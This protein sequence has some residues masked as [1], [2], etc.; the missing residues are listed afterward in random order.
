MVVSDL[1]K[2][3]PFWQLYQPYDA[4]FSGCG[5]GSWRR[6]RWKNNQRATVYGLDEAIPPGSYTSPS[7]HPS[8]NAIVRANK[9]GGGAASAQSP[10]RPAEAGATAFAAKPRRLPSSIGSNPRPTEAELIAK[11]S[12]LPRRT[13]VAVVVEAR[14]EAITTASR[15]GSRCTMRGTT[16][17]DKRSFSS[18]LPFSSGASLRAAEPSDQNAKAENSGLDVERVPSLLPSSPATTKAPPSEGAD[19]YAAWASA[20][21]F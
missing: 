14:L 13:T 12:F 8:L 17:R 4:S 18:A 11:W 16:L 20:E 10:A 3:I 6:R 7:V 9:R 5:C 15:A 2:V 1:D 19:G 21:P